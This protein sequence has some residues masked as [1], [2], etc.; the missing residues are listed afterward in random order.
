MAVGTSQIYLG[1][2]KQTCFQNAAQYAPTWFSA[3][4]AFPVGQYPS[5][6]RYGTIDV[7]VRDGLIVGARF[8][9]YGMRTQEFDLRTLTEK[10]GPPTSLTTKVVQNRMGA[11]YDSAT[12]I[13]E[14]QDLRVT[15]FG[16]M[17]TLDDG[18][19]T[20]DTPLAADL[21]KAQ[22]DALDKLLNPRKL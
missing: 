4:V 20:V 17:G 13:W 15:Y 10:Y 1:A 9:T 8:A 6:V 12:A 5:I 11:R 18:Q 14:R 19:V 22:A 3:T 7:L 21:R 16:T 2:G